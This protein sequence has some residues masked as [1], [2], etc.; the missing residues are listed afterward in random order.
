M[1]KERNASFVAFKKLGFCLLLPL[2]LSQ[3]VDDGS[4]A[5][6]AFEDQDDDLA[7]S[8][9]Q[10]WYGKSKKEPSKSFSACILFNFKEVLPDSANPAYWKG[11]Q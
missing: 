10:V 9:S 2:V 1:M 6:A 4:G 5:A 3:P 7:Y 8:S 11:I